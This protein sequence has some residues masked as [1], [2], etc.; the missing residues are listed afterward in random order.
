MNCQSLSARL[1]CYV[2]YKRVQILVV[3]FLIVS[4]TEKNLVRM[5]RDT[6][7]KAYE[8]YLY[9]TMHIENMKCG[10]QYMHLI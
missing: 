5:F 8:M 10:I 2:Q 6:S 9:N 3:R 4:K 7:V 1:L